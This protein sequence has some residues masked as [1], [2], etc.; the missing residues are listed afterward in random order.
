M[1]DEAILIKKRPKLS[2]SIV[3]AGFEGWGNALNI[4][5][6]TLSYLIRKLGAKTFARINPDHFYRYDESRPVVNIEDGILMSISPPGVSF[7]ALDGDSEPN[8]IILLKGDEPNLK[9]FYFAEELFSFFEKLHVTMFISLGSMYDNVLHT[10]RIVS[11]FASNKGLSSLLKDKNVLEVNYNGPSS[12][13]SV[14]HSEGR[15]RGIEC[16]SLWCHCPYYLQGTT[17]FGLLSHI[18]S[19]LSSIGNFKLE[20]DE[21]DKKWLELNQQIQAVID[22]NPELQQMIDELRKAKVRGSWE[23]ME[24]SIRKNGKVIPIS[25]FMKPG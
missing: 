7:Y 8:N 12:I 17:H 3:I 13:H 10:D 5:N 6:A 14:L 9:W 18:G 15:K 22:N 20:T 11:G 21:L 25:D 2:N 19:L 23:K 16:I 4:S 1:E 24:E